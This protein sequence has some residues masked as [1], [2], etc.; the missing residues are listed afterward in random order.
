ME[1]QNLLSTVIDV[2]A[3]RSIPRDIGKWGSIYSGTFVTAY[4]QKPFIS[5]NVWCCMSNGEYDGVNTVLQNVIESANICVT[6]D[7]RR[8]RASAPKY[9]EVSVLT[10]RSEWRLVNRL[11][12]DGW[13]ISR[14]RHRTIH[15]NAGGRS[16]IYLPSVWDERP[17]WDA[18]TLIRELV[19][20]SGGSLQDEV[21]IHEIGTYDIS[22]EGSINSGY[23]T[24]GSFNGIMTSSPVINEIL[25]DAWNFYRRFAS[26]DQLAY[27]ITPNFV[28]YENEGA[29]VRSYSDVATFA[30]LSQYLGQSDMA[31]P[32]IIN[33]L[34]RIQPQSTTDLAAR[35]S[36]L[37]DVDMAD[38]IEL[39]QFATETSNS[40][41]IFEDAD[42]GFGNPQ[43]MI[44]LLRIAKIL[45]NVRPLVE[46][47]FTGF[48]LNY[49]KFLFHILQEY[50]AFAANWIL[51]TLSAAYHLNK[52][53]FTIYKDLLPPLFASCE[54]AL[55]NPDSITLEAC[56]LNGLLIFN[57]QVNV[58][59]ILS[60]WRRLQQEWGIGGFRY[61]LDQPWYRT[62]VTS[63]VVE[64]CFLL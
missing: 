8:S 27:M 30:K 39:T 15:V 56:A 25:R 26:N 58:Q 24:Q 53:F 6:E 9:F 13:D 31:F 45:P 40:R 10:P 55:K 63:H 12:N 5:E 22:E 57:R 48:V 44:V 23:F 38:P 18:A 35:I 11:P 50:G 59:P 47:S 2:F 42:L 64:D 36:L 4:F 43:I 60:K 37:L 28:S 14:E 34:N 46:E 62:D 3:N 20:K 17:E 7:P 49:R 1:D 16:A 52:M 32:Y 21:I 29:N 33:I 41:G 54:Q 51:Q 19:E 61:Y